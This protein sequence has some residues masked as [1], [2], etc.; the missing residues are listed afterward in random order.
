MLVQRGY[1][2]NSRKSKGRTDFILGCV[3]TTCYSLPVYILQNQALRWNDKLISSPFVEKHGHLKDLGRYDIPNMH[4]C[5]V[6]C[7]FCHEPSCLQREMRRY[8]FLFYTISRQIWILNQCYWNDSLTCSFSN[9]GYFSVN[10]S[11][12]DRKCEA[13]E[14]TQDICRYFDDTIEIG[15][16]LAQNPRASIENSV[17]T[18][19]SCHYGVAWEEC[20]YPGSYHCISSCQIIL[21]LNWLSIQVSRSRIVLLYYSQLS[22]FTNRHFISDIPEFLE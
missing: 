4:N 18:S 13:K 16:K 17:S 12:Y 11:L 21:A 8:V 5:L 1:V 3:Q 9:A 6:H 20:A 19:I 14:I 15:F 10:A 22:R 2:S 7:R